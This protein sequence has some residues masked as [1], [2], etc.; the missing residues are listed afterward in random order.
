MASKVLVA[1][2]MGGGM[3]GLNFVSGRDAAYVGHI[4]NFRQGAPA[5]VLDYTEAITRTANS[6]ADSAVL[7][8]LDTTGLAVGM[9]VYANDVLPR[10]RGLTILSIGSGQVTLSGIV[11]TTNTGVTFTFATPQQL[12]KMNSTTHAAKNHA[13]HFTQEL[14]ADAF[15]VADTAPNA[16]KTKAAIISNVGPMRR[17]LFMESGGG[18]YNFK[19]R[20]VDNSVRDGLETDKSPRLTSHNDQTSIWET[21]NPE[22]AVR[23]WG[24]GIADFFLGEIIG[25]LNQPLATVSSSGAQ[26][27][28]T[29]TTVSGFLISSN[30]LVRRVPGYSEYTLYD[31]DFTHEIT[32]GEKLKQAATVVGS[33]ETNLYLKAAVK[34][35]EIARDYQDVLLD[36]MEITDP[37]FSVGSAYPGSSPVSPMGFCASLKQVARMILANN[38]TRGYTASRSVGN[39]VTLSTEVTSGTATRVAGSTTVT[40][41]MPNHRFFT[42]TTN[43]GNESDSVLVTGLGGTLQAEGYKITLHPTDP[44]NKFTLTTVENT[45]LTNVTVTARLKHNWKVGGKVFVEGA[46]FDIVT[47]ANGYTVIAIGS[48]YS[49][50]VQTT[51]TGAYPSG[52]SLAVKAKIINLPKQ[53]IY[54]ST[55]G[56]G[57]DSHDYANHDQLFALNHGLKYFQS[58]VDRMTDADVVTCSITEFGRTIGVNSKGTDHGWGNYAFVIGKSVKGNKIYGDAI[59]LD[60]AGPH[61]AGF[62]FA[63]TSHYQYC[64]TFAKWFGATDAQILELFPDLQYWPLAE[65]TLGFV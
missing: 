35:N 50:T 2:S 32:I 63:S 3:D 4:Q 1:I 61:N 59:D 9:K 42:S 22:G 26:P 20:N 33:N 30:G 21:N 28:I 46:G 11:T 40:V 29:G 18:V 5:N 48:N 15:N 43:P 44:N 53:I 19:V 55:T 64:A 36:A 25:T 38:P 31:E 14:I 24:G 37:P 51:A 34:A 65:R 58:L 10:T 23:G 60:P 56:I 39:V 41:T 49:F 27:F 45:A 7:T 16:A 8:A 12:Y 13:L 52:N 62:L 47:P 17:K 57:W 6:T 54:T